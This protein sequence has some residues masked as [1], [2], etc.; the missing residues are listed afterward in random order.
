MTA[1]KAQKCMVCR[2]RAV[3]PAKVDSYET[4]LEHDG[5]K[6]AISVADLV[7]LKCRHCGEVYLDEDADERLSEGR[8]PRRPAC[9]LRRRSARAVRDWG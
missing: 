4:E 1:P 5:R 7:V 3:A 6:Y 8:S 2:E 9:S